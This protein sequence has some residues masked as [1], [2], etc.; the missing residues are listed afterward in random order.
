[1]SGY[2]YIFADL[3]TNTTLTELPLKQVQFDQRLN[4]V[5]SFKGRLNIS[6][7]AVQKLQPWTQTPGGRTA[8]YVD[9]DGRIVWGGVV[10][11]KQ[12][13]QGGAASGTPFVLEIS[14]S[15][16]FWYFRNKRVITS[17]TAFTNVDQLTIAQSLFNTAQGVRNGNIGVAVPTNLSGVL[18]SQ[19]W[20][21]VDRKKVGQAVI[22]MAVLDN[23]FDWQIRTDY[24]TGG[25]PAGVPGK[26]LALG[27]PRLGNSFITSGWMFEFPGNIVGYNWP[28]D[29]S[30]QAVT[31]YVQGQGA[32]ANMVQSSNTITS[33]LDAGYPQLDETFPLKDQTDPTAV[34]ARAVAIAK[35]Y[36]SPITLPE[37][38]VRA[39]ADPVLGSYVVGDDAN[40]RIT[41]A[42]FPAQGGSVGYDV[43]WRIV[44]IRVQPQ[45]DGSPERV[46]LTL[47]AIP[48]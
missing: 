9:R 27:Y 25:Q 39:D 30:A 37:L 34:A 42:Q 32:G 18:R 21:G 11:T 17:D 5:G 7:P 4:D 6:D 40:I 8:L 23:G 41:S 3:I 29:S 22:D 33:L 20:K 10:V 26:Q 1:V 16:F 45:D 14:A 36:S 19:T 12:Y 35:A 46:F 13:T 2:R 44:A 48:F 31:A 43:F 38:V 24:G 15:E 47:G 28:E